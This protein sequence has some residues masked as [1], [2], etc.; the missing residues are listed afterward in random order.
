M[1]SHKQGNP[2][3]KLPVSFSTENFQQK[4]ETWIIFYV[5]KENPEI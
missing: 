3:K 1:K 5:E 2:K 4:G